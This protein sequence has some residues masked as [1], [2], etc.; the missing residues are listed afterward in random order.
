MPHPV[1]HPPAPRRL[2]RIAGLLYLVVAICGGL[3][4]TIRNTVDAPGDAPALARAIAAHATLVRA[5]VAV[6]LVTAVSWLLTA[7]ALYLLLEHVSVN[8]ARAMVLFTATGV[9]VMCLNLVHQHGALVLVTDPAYA[10][11]LGRE[12]VEAAARHAFSTLRA[13]E[14]VSGVFF[15]LWLLP[16]GYLAYASRLFPRVLGVLLAIGC[17]GYLANTF[18]LLLAPPLGKTLSPYFI[19]PSAVA[20]LAMVLWLLVKGVRSP[21]TQAARAAA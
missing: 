2:A 8:A 5:G 18:T 1:P 11:A 21:G 17:L 15:G 9:A 13:G 12:G 19:T 4:E 16:M 3:G 10:A 20:E 7:M 6:D 14:L